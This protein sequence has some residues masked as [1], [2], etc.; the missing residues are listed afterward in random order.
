MLQELQIKALLLDIES[1]IDKN[2]HPYFRLSLQGLNNRY[3][4]AFS[5]S[6]NQATFT[7]LTNTPHNF[8]NRQVLITYQELPNKDNQGVF[9]KVKELQIS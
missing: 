6:L 4:Y 2:N 5:N 7:S 3:F 9:F 8:I 1:K